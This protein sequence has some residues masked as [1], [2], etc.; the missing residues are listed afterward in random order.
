MKTLELLTYSRWHKLAG[1]EN[2]HSINGYQETAP[3]SHRAVGCGKC[4]YMPR[5]Q[6][7]N[8]QWVS[9]ELEEMVCHL[10][11]RGWRG[12]EYRGAPW[13]SHHNYLGQGWKLVHED[14][15]HWARRG[16]PSRPSASLT[17]RR[18]HSHFSKG[19][20]IKGQIIKTEE[21]SS[22]LVKQT[23]KNQFGSL[24]MEWASHHEN[25]HVAT[26]G[27]PPWTVYL[28]HRR[29]VASGI[30]QHLKMALTE[31]WGRWNAKSRGIWKVT[32]F[33]PHFF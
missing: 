30:A 23:N 24:V 4:P 22:P 7:S 6:R 26:L 21:D 17:R 19:R 12:R 2:T 32:H 16:V 11:V 27:M 15:R 31:K 9:Q 18:S 5:K 20:V 13:Y 28:S 14:K 33:R 10:S 1:V 8:N 25:P 29:C 3:E